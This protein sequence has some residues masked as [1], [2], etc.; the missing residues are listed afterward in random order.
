VAASVL[1][2]FIQNLA[3]IY[4]DAGKVRVLDLAEIVDRALTKG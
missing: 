1:V 4:L 2:G 3:L